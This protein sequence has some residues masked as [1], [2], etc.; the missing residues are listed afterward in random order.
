MKAL[1]LKILF[2]LVAPA[3]MVLLWVLS[4]RPLNLP[5]LGGF[6]VD[7][8]AHFLA[9][10]A[11]AVALSLWFGPEK[12]LEK[13][14]IS[15]LVVVVLA[16]LYGAM[17]EVHQSFVPGRD[18]DVFDLLADSIGAAAGAWIGVRPAFRRRI[19]KWSNS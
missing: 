13:K 18:A 12:F 15:I 17:D 11:L 10:A 14:Y 9:Y 8:V 5:D 1:I 4:S 7:K 3:E 16:S 2:R 19:E 6:G